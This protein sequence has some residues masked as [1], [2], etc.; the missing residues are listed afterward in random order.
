[1][2]D[3]SFLDGVVLS[4]YWRGFLVRVSQSITMKQKNQVGDENRGYI[5]RCQQ[6]D[7]IKL[8][9][10]QNQGFLYDLVFLKGG[11]G[12]GLVVAPQIY[13]FIYKWGWYDFSIT[14]NIIK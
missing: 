3:T 13:L 10:A 8:P 6:H 7:I 9:Y 4:Q 5:K 2:K 12:V 1:M 14:K 11:G